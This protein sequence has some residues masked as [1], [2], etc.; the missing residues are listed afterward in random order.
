MEG[1]RLSP[2]S[3]ECRRIVP[4][5]ACCFCLSLSP[6]NEPVVRE[7]GGTLPRR[8]DRPRTEPR[9]RFG[10]LVRIGPASSRDRGDAY[11]EGAAET[12]PTAYGRG[13]GDTLYAERSDRSDRSQEKVRL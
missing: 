2:A 10:I 8:C 7:G 12:L 6:M 11:G 13:G 5:A 3:G 9:D 4:I 1:G